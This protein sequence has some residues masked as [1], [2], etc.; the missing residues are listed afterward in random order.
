MI[1]IRILTIFPA[2]FD[3]FLRF[4]NPARAME[5]GQMSVGAVDLREFT[6]D[7]HRTTDDYPYGGGTGMIMKPE[8][9]VAGIR[10]MR[11]VMRNPLAILMTPQGAL[12]NQPVAERLAGLDSVLIVCGRYE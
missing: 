11:S 8:P 1:D 12:F 4:G 9:V 6:F 3:S 10:H 2:I 7:R 5:A